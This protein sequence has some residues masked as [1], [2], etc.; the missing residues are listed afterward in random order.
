MILKMLSF[1][2]D[3]AIVTLFFSQNILKLSLQNS[4]LPMPT[5]AILFYHDPYPILI[6]PLSFLLPVK[7]PTL[8]QTSEYHKY[9]CN[10]SSEVLLTPLKCFLLLK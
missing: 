5:N 8:S 3:N 9:L 2:K 1:R 4:L 10:F 6:K 7:R